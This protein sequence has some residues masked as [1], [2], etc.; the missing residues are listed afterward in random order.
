MWQRIVFGAEYSFRFDLTF[1]LHL[2][3]YGV[4][5]IDDIYHK[6]DISPLSCLV[7]SPILIPFEVSMKFYV[8]LH[9]DKSSTV[10]H[11]FSNALGYMSSKIQPIWNIALYG[12]IIHSPHWL[13]NPWMDSK[14]YLKD[15]NLSKYSP[16]K[17]TFFISTVQLRM[18]V[19]DIFLLLGLW[20][21]RFKKLLGK[22]IFWLKSN[23]QKPWSNMSQ[24]KDGGYGQTVMVCQ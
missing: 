16:A 11:I 10:T 8:N 23:L 24:K 22:S 13:P 3:H 7:I 21:I 6:I 2:F 15:K 17:H 4:A 20:K 12:F 1:I 9:I 14:D 18:I 19:L 5:V